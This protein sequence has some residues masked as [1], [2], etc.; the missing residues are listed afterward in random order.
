MLCR[1]S[2]KGGEWEL[3]LRQ[4]I[5]ELGFDTTTNNDVYV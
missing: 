5:E 2:S 4:A 3:G 1:W